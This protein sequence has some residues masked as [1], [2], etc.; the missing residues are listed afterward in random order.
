M[1][2]RT[3]FLFY[4]YSPS[5][6]SV[7]PDGYFLNG[8]YRSKGDNLHNIEEGKCCKPVNHPKLYEHCYHEYIRYEFDKKGWTTC[9]KTGYYVVGVFRDHN[10]DWL[11]DIDYFKCC[12]MWTG[13]SNHC[14]LYATIMF[15][16]VT[17]EPLL[18]TF[19]IIFK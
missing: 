13:N 7:C 10:K 19:I 9:K 17:G 15:F 4:E 12:K 8:L 6:W 14:F 1:N 18:Y 5:T 16:R 3:C 2:D 11:H